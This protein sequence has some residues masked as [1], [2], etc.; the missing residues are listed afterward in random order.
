MQSFQG[1]WLCPAAKVAR[2][3]SDAAVGLH[4]AQ[5]TGDLDETASERF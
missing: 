2:R 4:I 1:F 3:Y 5:R